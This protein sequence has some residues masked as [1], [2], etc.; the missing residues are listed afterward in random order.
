MHGLLYNVKS[1]IEKYDGAD[2]QL[3]L[4]IFFNDPDKEWDD[5]I[6]N[7]FFENDY[8]RGSP[9][10]VKGEC[11][12]VDSAIYNEFYA[13]LQKLADSGIIYSQA[14]DLDVGGIIRYTEEG[15]IVTC[16]AEITD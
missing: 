13:N 15:V 12:C 9:E 2:I 6:A 11:D 16:E 7:A 5:N 10:D 1:D 4:K 14:A 8:K 3:R